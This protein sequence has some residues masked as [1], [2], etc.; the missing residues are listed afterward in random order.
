MKILNS[1]KQANLDLQSDATLEPS[2]AYIQNKCKGMLSSAALRTMIVC[3]TDHKQRDILVQS[4]SSWWTSSPFDNVNKSNVEAKEHAFIANC[5][6]EAYRKKRQDNNTHMTQ[7][8]LAMQ[9]KWE[10]KHDNSFVDQA[11]TNY[12]S[13]LGLDETTYRTEYENMLKGEYGWETQCLMMTTVA[14]PDYANNVAY[15]AQNYPTS[16]LVAEIN[17]CMFA[18]AVCVLGN[19]GMCIL[20]HQYGLPGTFFMVLGDFL[21]D[22]IRAPTAVPGGLFT[23]ALLKAHVQGITARVKENQK[24]TMSDAIDCY[25]EISLRVK[26]LKFISQSRLVAYMTI[27]IAASLMTRY[28]KMDGFNHL[29]EEIKQEEQ[30]R[31]S[32]NEFLKWFKIK[33]DREGYKNKTYKLTYDKAF[34]FTLEYTA[35]IFTKFFKLVTGDMFIKGTVE[36]GEKE[37]EKTENQRDDAELRAAEFKQQAEEAERLGVV[38]EKILKEIAAKDPKLVER[39]RKIAEEQ[40]GKTRQDTEAR[41]GQ[42]YLFDSS[43]SDAHLIKF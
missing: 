41:A 24:E 6:Y 19:T 7:Y 39:A 14:N 21:P 10:K 36:P 42:L 31:T 28:Y 29:L 33:D 3:E 12:T 18:G 30:K 25:M 11:Y 35:Y 23:V 22:Y 43:T 4:Y 38:N 32:Y 8:L 40:A 27:S 16:T 13:K 15:F 37:L 2:V 5:Y 1:A 26:M 9:Q 34:L 20:T 17:A